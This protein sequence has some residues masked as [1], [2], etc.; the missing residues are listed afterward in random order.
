MAKKI[1]FNV[2]YDEHSGELKAIEPTK[3][4][5]AESQLLQMEVLQDALDVLHDVLAERKEI[6][7]QV[8]SRLENIPRA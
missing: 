5:E 8:L 3:R 2:F 7:K 6:F 1:A 4:F